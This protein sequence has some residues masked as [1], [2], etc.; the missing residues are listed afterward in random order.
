VAGLV[1]AMTIAGTAAGAPK[2]KVLICH[3][4]R[5]LPGHIIS[6]PETAAGSHEGRHA[7]AVEADYRVT[8]G[9]PGGTCPARTGGTDGG[10][11]GGTSSGGPS[12]GGTTGGAAGATARGA[13]P[14]TGLPVWIPLLAAGALLGGGFWLV[15]R[16]PGESS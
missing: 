3:F 14:F 4:D 13:L 15:R 1:L 5:S 11:D 2:T 8:S 7:G 10:T 16:R 9:S 6:V 12:G